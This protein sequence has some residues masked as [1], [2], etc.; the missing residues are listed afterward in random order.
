MGVK[1]S[2]YQ[3]MESEVRSQ[4]EAFLTRDGS[5]YSLSESL[6]V[7]S[8]P[9]RLSFPLPPFRPPMIVSPLKPISRQTWCHV[10]RH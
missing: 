8:L 5:S 10:E 7:G 1:V 2:T 9:R 3:P 4:M 6:S